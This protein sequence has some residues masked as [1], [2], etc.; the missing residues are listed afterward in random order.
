MSEIVRAEALRGFRELVRELGGDGDA[1]L[2]ASGI[3]PA[4][5]ED[6]DAYIS[7]RRVI[8]VLERAAKAL[9]CPDFGLRFARSV[10]DVLGPISVAMRNAE[11]ARQALTIAKRYM[12]F[13]NPSIMMD[14]EPF[15]DGHEFVCVGL[16]MTRPPRNVTQTAERGV[17]M[18]HNALVFL[19]GSAYRPKHVWF[20]HAPLSPLPVYRDV[21]GETPS[22]NKD[23]NGLAVASSLLDAP[24]PAANAQMRRITEHYLA[25]VAPPRADSDAIA[26]RAR[27]V[28]AQLVRAGV[29][30]QGELAR[31]L[32][33]HERTLQRRLKSEETSFEALR[34]DVRR[35]IAQSYLAQPSVPL[36]HIAEMLGYAEASAFTRAARRWFGASPR[37]V[38]KKL[39]G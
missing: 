1:L 14:I 11:T 24:H 7:F 39:S 23:K 37:D 6:I 10:T 20:E 9:N 15:G 18:V 32:G 27:L 26:P 28:I 2:R 35:E 3:D 33:M 36:S 13:H 38:R 19:C 17:A 34:D 25:S 16:S 8:D 31:A 22:F 5:I 29:A 30:T 12:H 4:S 21:F